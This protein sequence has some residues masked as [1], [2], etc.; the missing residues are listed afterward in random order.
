[1]IFNNIVIAFPAFILVFTVT[2]ELAH[3]LTLRYEDNFKGIKILWRMGAVQVIPKNEYRYKH[4]ALIHFSGLA[5]NLLTYPLLYS[6]LEIDFFGYFLMSLVGAS[7]DVVSY[8]LIRKNIKV[9]K[10]Q[11]NLIYPFI[12]FIIIHIT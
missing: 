8:I 10:T 12:H 3:I 1:M 6:I 5:I 11:I 7:V 2:H 4:P 9:M